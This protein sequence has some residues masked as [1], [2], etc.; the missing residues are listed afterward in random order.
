M[1][2]ESIG[3]NILKLRRAK[4]VTQE[5]LAE[6]TGVTKTSVSKW[7]T[8]VTLPDIQILPLLASYFDVSIDDL[9]DYVSALDQ[10]Q[11]R[12]HYHRLADA[13]SS[14][15]YTGVLE[16]CWELVRKYYSCYPFLQQM[17]ILMLN[18]IDAADTS[19]NRQKAFHLAFTLCE[20]ILTECQDRTICKN[21]VSF[22]A[23]LNL[24]QGKA[25]LVIE[26]LEKEALDVNLAGDTDVLLAMAYLTADKKKEAGETAQTGMYH[27]L[28]GMIRHGVCLLQAVEHDISYGMLL[29]T[30][31]DKLIDNFSLLH[32]NPNITGGYEY[33]AAIFLAGRNNRII[34]SENIT[35]EKRLL[36]MDEDVFIRLERYIVSCRQLFLDDM[37]LHGDDFFRSLDQWLENMDSGTVASRSRSS[38]LKS[39]LDSLKH[40]LFAGLKD[41]KRLQKL[42]EEIQNVENQPSDKNL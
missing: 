42:A 2:I 39:V 33:Q 18:H 34:Q 35:D 38:V 15:P 37:R 21:A 3:N 27:S 32:L 8:G 9:L 11:I 16:E 13:F 6:F 10:K 1:G 29:L 36:A 28:M 4:G 25:D 17:I 20:R 22:R 41:Q 14:R 5:V 31:L 23:M 19:E 30:R 12:F 26:E 24:Y 7:E 40:P